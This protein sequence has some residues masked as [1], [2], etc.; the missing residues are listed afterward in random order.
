MQGNRKAQVNRVP[1]QSSV[2]FPKDYHPLRVDWSDAIDA[3]DSYIEDDARDGL[4]VHG[5]E[6]AG[7]RSFMKWVHWNLRAHYSGNVILPLHYTS[8]LCAHPAGILISLRSMLQIEDGRPAR[9]PLVRIA[10]NASAGGNMAF[11]NVTLSLSESSI[12][13]S[14]ELLRHLEE[15]AQAIMSTSESARVILSIQEP[16]HWDVSAVGWLVRSFCLETLL[17][18]PRPIKFIVS[19]TSD[20]GK[21]ALEA[22]DPSRFRSLQLPDSVTGPLLEEAIGDVA[23]ILSVLR[24]LAP[25]AARTAAR[26]LL[27]TRAGKPGHVINDLARLRMAG[28]TVGGRP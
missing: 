5:S 21:G 23:S 12:G 6:G 1:A 27:E 8:P 18:S 19:T 22:Q 3:L 7:V 15:V 17:E 9:G 10:E 13:E 16:E 25:E 20:E 28:T 14:K 24:D 2:V 26:I 4:I 11:E